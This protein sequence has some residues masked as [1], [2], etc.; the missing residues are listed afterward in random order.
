M[1]APIVPIERYL[2][3]AAD[4]VALLEQAL[5][6][7]HG[8]LEP[9]DDRPALASL[10]YATDHLSFALARYRAEHAQGDP[11]QIPLLF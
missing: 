7:V 6:T 8:D 11:R 3:L 9:G 1:G 5:I 4:S 10:F 2:A